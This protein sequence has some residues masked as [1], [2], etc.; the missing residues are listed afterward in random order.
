MPSFASTLVPLRR[1]LAVPF[2]RLCRSLDSLGKDS[3]IA[4]SKIVYPG[5]KI[6]IK[7]EVLIPSIFPRPTRFRQS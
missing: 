6:K 4:A 3:K 1:P 5:V 2:D 7:N